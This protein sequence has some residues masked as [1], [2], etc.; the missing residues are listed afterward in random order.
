MLKLG[1]LKHKL[2]I[3]MGQIKIPNILSRPEPSY[4]SQKKIGAKMPLTQNLKR[5]LPLFTY[6]LDRDK[7][8]I[9]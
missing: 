1:K 2:K 8:K 6:I 3:K 7:T 4:T 5:K 9:S